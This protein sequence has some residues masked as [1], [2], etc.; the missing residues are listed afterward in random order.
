MQMHILSA[1]VEGRTVRS[2]VARWASDKRGLLAI[3]TL[4]AL[5]RQHRQPLL[6]ACEASRHTEQRS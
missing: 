1:R 3:E 5:Q 4:G 6:I 2:Q